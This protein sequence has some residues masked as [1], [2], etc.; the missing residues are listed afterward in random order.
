MRSPASRARPRRGAPR[1]RG[2]AISNSRQSSLSDVCAR[3]WAPG[4][5]NRSL[6]RTVFAEPCSP[7]IARRGC[8]PPARNA[9]NSQAINTKSFRLARLRNELSAAMDPPRSGTDSGNIPAG[10]RAH[11]WASTYPLSVRSE[12]TARY[13][14]QRGRDK[15]VRHVPRCGRGLCSWPRTALRFQEVERLT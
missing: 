13:C 3:Q 5:E 12:S 1:I 8:G 6:E 7:D 11:W 9:A 10:R 2:R 15:C 14:H 4:S